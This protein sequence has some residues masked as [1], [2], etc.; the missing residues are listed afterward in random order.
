MNVSVF[1]LLSV[2]LVGLKLTGNFD[3]S[4]FWPIMLALPDL[5]LFF[6]RVVHEIILA[7]RKQLE[8]EKVKQ[9]GLEIVEKFNKSA[10][11]MIASILQGANDAASSEPGSPSSDPGVVSG[12]GHGDSGGNPN[13]K[14]SG[15]G[16]GSG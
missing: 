3:H 4:W 14:S 1:G 10:D 16:R 11:D 7:R 12:S 6:V 5:G 8:V 15:V 2:L 9:R 13:Q